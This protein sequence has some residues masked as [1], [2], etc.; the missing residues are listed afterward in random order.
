MQGDRLR[1]LLLNHPLADGRPL[2][3]NA[4]AIATKFTAQPANTR[5]ERSVISLLSAAFSNIRGFSMDFRAQ[6][7]QTVATALAERQTPPETARHFIASLEQLITRHNTEFRG[8]ADETSIEAELAPE[9]V[10]AI[11]KFFN[12][13]ASKGGLVC[14]EYRDPPRVY[15][16]AKYSALLRV[17]AQAIV[18]GA[19]LAMFLPFV[20]ESKHAHAPGIQAFFKELEGRLE[21]GRRE[22]LKAC[23]EMEPNAER[24]VALPERIALYKLAP[25]YDSQFATGIQTRTFLAYGQGLGQELTR[26]AWEWVAGAERDFFIKRDPE[27]VPLLSAQFDPVAFYW[28]SRGKIPQTAAELG[29]A[30]GMFNELYRTRLPEDLWTIATG[31]ERE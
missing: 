19:S 14:C 13:V 26:E 9:E 17:A 27:I 16:P 18:R 20:A 25:A 22:L 2:F 11:T 30:I 10:R 5:K 3:N 21:Y 12:D 15:G 28:R 1:K 7:I 8:T 29:T 6:L 4:A 23:R 24:R 31:E